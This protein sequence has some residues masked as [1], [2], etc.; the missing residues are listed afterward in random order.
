VKILVIGGAGYIGCHMVDALIKRAHDIVI[1]DDLST[2]HREFIPQDKL[3]I[4]NLGDALL[5]EELFST[6]RFDA[7]MHFAAFIQVGESVINPAKY[8]DNNVIKTLTLLNIMIKH[9]VKNF[10][11]SSTAAIFGDPQTNLIDETHAKNPINPYGRSKWMVE[12]ILHDYEKAYGLQSVSLRYFNAA[13]ADLQAR[14]GECHEPESH[15]IPLLLQVASGQHKNIELYGDDYPTL[16]GTCIRDYIHVVDI[17][18]AHLLALETLLNKKKISAAYNI[19][20][21]QGHSV[22]QVID[23]VTAITGKK[24][25]LVVQQ[26][27]PG[28]PPQLIANSKKINAELGWVPHHS[29]LETIIESAWRWE[30]KRSSH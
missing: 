5:L 9:N 20:L 29:N 3:I 15:L 7:V 16:D 26:R 1:L 6:H 10:I 14:F 27:R 4:G 30:L 13:G 8:Y 24:I 12:Q 18:A 21:G 28:D 25:T 22:K 11:F 2:G 17:A 19:G 23:M